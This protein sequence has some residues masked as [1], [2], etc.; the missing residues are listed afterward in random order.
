[1]RLDSHLLTDFPEDIKQ[2]LTDTYGGWYS[3][4]SHMES[5]DNR[6]N[7]PPDDQVWVDVVEK[8][9]NMCIMFNKDIMDE[10]GITQED[11]QTEAGFMAACETVKNSGLQV[12]GQAV[13]PVLLHANLWI[14]SSLD[15]ILAW[16]FGA[17]PVDEEGH[18]RHLELSPGYKNALKFV[19]NCIQNGYLDVNTLTIDEA[20]NLTYLDAD[21]VFCWI[22]NQAQQDKTGRAWV[23]YG[24]ILADNGAVPAMPVA[25][26]AGTGWIQTLVSK[27]CENP[28]KIA[29]LLTWASSR[30][31]L[32][33]NYYGNEGTDYTIDENGIVTRT[34]EFDQ[35]YVDDYQSNMLMWPFANTSFERNTEPVPDPTTNRGVEV[36]LMP[37][38]GSYEDTYIYDDSLLDFEDS[39]VIEPSSDLGV[40]LSQV[41]SYLESQKAKIVSA[42][43]DE[44]FEEEYQNMLT[45]LEE[46]GIQDIDAEYDKVLQQ[47]Y[48]TMGSTIEDVNASLYQ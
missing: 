4:P 5:A 1:M 44:A 42:A 36:S 2:A 13:I 24:P 27:D 32:L 35:V 23:S 40:K 12:D 8:G 22:G 45:T 47:N 34:E 37:A 10:L 7:Y 38:L 48:E 31:G 29:E 19:N 28:E 20:A 25:Q 9:S 30:E 14:E 17:V 26:A 11:V 18:Y 3:F 6:E 39:N 43:N 33:V 16:N 15:S 41:D 46:Y 21:R